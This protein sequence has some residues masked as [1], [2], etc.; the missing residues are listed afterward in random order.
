MQFVCIIFFPKNL[1]VLSFLSFVVQYLTIK[2][3][4]NNFKFEANNKKFRTLVQMRFK[5]LFNIKCVN[6][7]ETLND[8]HGAILLCCQTGMCPPCFLQGAIVHKCNKGCYI[9]SP[10][11]NKMWPI[12]R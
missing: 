6:C 4:D 2:S 9:L 10:F 3:N 12:M 8:K 1:F 5:S 7:E 11:K